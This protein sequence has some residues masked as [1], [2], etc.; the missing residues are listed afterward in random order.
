[1]KRLINKFQNHTAIIAAFI[2]VF[3]LGSIS[4][5][6]AASFDDE[7]VI[8]EWMTTPFETVVFEEAIVTESWMSAPFESG[9][10]LETIIVEEWMKTPFEIELD[11]ESIA[12]ED[13]MKSPLCLDLFQ[14][15][16]FPPW[17]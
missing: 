12:V 1:M 17:F 5:A 9:V 16:I 8:E 2:S 10:D 3:F 13:W 6:N 7:I 14:S 4:M 11:L 15:N